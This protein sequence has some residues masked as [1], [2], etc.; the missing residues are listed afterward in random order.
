MHHASRDAGQGWCAYDDWYLALRYL[1][2]RS[3][4]RIRKALYVDLD[5]HQGNGVARVSGEAPRGAREVLIVACLALF[6][7]QFNWQ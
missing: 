2:D 4:G 1:R 3:G 7:G 5:V 6:L